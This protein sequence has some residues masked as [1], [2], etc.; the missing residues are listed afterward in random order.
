[1]NTTKREK[2]EQNRWQAAPGGEA[3]LDSAN[4]C[5]RV[6]CW[7]GGLGR[8]R[9]VGARLLLTQSPSQRLQAR[10][11]NRDS[12][13]RAWWYGPTRREVHVGTRENLQ[14]RTAATSPAG[15][16]LCHGARQRPSLQRLPVRPPPR[17]PA[18][19]DERICACR[20][21]LWDGHI[22]EAGEVDVGNLELETMRW[23]KSKRLH[24]RTMAAAAAAMAAPA[25]LRGGAMV[26]GVES[27]APRPWLRHGLRW[28]W[29]ALRVEEHGPTN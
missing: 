13:A 23:G 29:A 1:M 14:R 26:E 18:R 25:R 3:G 27:T 8:P 4:R 16:A 20:T 15:P 6:R 12:A 19:P 9:L 11:R 7:G 28:N 21:S 5:Q 10:K 17:G 24:E 22:G 2:W